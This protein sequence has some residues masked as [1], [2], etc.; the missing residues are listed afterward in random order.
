MWDVD[1]LSNSPLRGQ[2]T[3]RRTL[4]LHEPREGP[5]DSHPTFRTLSWTKPFSSL[6]APLDGLP[7]AGHRCLIRSTSIHP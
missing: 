1:G 7:P 2:Q 3:R 5:D 4:N 6:A